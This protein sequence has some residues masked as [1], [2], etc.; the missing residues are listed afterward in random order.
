[1]NDPDFQIANEEAI[2]RVWELVAKWENATELSTGQ[3]SII[4]KAFAAEVRKALEGGK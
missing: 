4:T 1:M 2:G 3:S